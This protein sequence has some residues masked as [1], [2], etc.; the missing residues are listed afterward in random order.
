MS[1]ATNAVAPSNANA[2][3]EDVVARPALADDPPALSRTDT[4]GRA[5]ETFGME[6]RKT[7]A[8]VAPPLGLALA[9]GRV[10]GA[11]TLRPLPGTASPATMAVV[12]DTAKA[13]TATQ[14][15]AVNVA[16]VGL[17]PVA[18]KAATETPSLASGVGA[19]LETTVA[20][21]GPPYVAKMAK[22][23]VVATGLAVF[24]TQEAMGLD[25][26][27]LPGRA[28]LAAH[29]PAL[30]AALATTSVAPPR[31]SRDGLLRDVVVGRLAVVPAGRPLEVEV[32]R[33]VPPVANSPL[34]H[35]LDDDVVPVDDAD[36]R[37]VETRLA[38]TDTLAA[39]GRPPLLA[40]VVVDEVPPRR[41][42]PSPAL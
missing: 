13:P 28:R 32:P 22:A 27:T 26:V 25:V 33:R 8:R 15:A 16:D 3:E 36:A 23:P 7:L 12:A 5:L 6:V 4:V 2:L 9:V 30:D 40:V 34:G 29:P 14:V 42:S 24:S 41:D 37:P 10:A 21:E 1:A 35:G 31:L 20:L 38:A 18:M 39:T 11:V 17:G 19:A